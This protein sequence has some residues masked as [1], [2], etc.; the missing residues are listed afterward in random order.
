[1]AILSHLANAYTVA[2]SDAIRPALRI[3]SSFAARTMNIT[4]GFAYAALTLDRSFVYR[5]YAAFRILQKS[6][7]SSGQFPSSVRTGAYY[8][9]GRPLPPVHLKEEPCRSHRPY[10][11]TAKCRWIPVS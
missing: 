11:L 8:E 3:D 10:V 5:G 4:L 7:R 2:A 6:A 9:S 1:V